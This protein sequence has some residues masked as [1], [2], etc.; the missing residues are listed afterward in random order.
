MHLGAVLETV[1]EAASSSSLK[2]SLAATQPSLQREMDTDSQSQHAQHNPGRSS[3]SSEF[4][5]HFNESD[6]LLLSFI[7]I[8]VAASGSL[9]LAMIVFYPFRHLVS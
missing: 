1:T 4:A 8:R 2:T 5:F 7:P 6:L 9:Y 3:Q